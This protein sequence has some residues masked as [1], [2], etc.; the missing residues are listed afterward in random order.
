M[1]KLLLIFTSFLFFTFV[2]AGALATVFGSRIQIE[3]RIQHLITDESEERLT[4][5]LILQ[6]VDNEK[7]GL[8]LWDRVGKPLWQ[9]FRNFTVGKMSS[10]T[11][12]TLEKKL[13]DAGYPFQLTP[14]DFK[15]LQLM[16]GAGFFL[17]ILLLF[18]PLSKDI[19][20]IFIFAVVGGTFGMMYPNYYLNAKRKQRTVAIQKAM[21]DFF[22]MVNVS[23]E[24][25]MGLDA[26]IAKVCKRMEG[27]LSVEFLRTL[28]EMK[29]GKSRK[30]AFSDLRDRVPSEPFQ[31]VMSALIQADH[32]G[33]GM[34]KVLR[35]QTRRIREQRRHAAKEQALKAPV[36]MMIPMVL[37]MFPTLFVVL[38]GP[39]VVQLVT[40]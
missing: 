36:K 3:R 11:A 19:G 22:D 15:L 18:L 17:L 33:I 38:L 5:D 16:L 7:S 24:A 20:R 32:L 31:S 40:K 4:E 1:E 8:S 28:D 37:F 27:P 39:I 13:R 12:R 14:A 21:S 30:E 2:T 26:A 23:I 35:A 9:K 10:H 25:G 34:A 6:E 29:L